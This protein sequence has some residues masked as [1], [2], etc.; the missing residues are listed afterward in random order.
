MELRCSVNLTAE[1]ALSFH[2]LNCLYVVGEPDRSQQPVWTSRKA[3]GLSLTD[4]YY[5]ARSRG[6]KNHCFK[7]G[8]LSA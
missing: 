1:T 7:A 6:E 3:E 4:V 5:F 2:E 8:G